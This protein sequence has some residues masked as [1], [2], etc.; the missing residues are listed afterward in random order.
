MSTGIRK[1]TLGEGKLKKITESGNSNAKVLFGLGTSNV[2]R[3]TFQT[4][5]EVLQENNVEPRAFIGVISI[6]SES[7]KSKKEV[8]I[9]I[10]VEGRNSTLGIFKYFFRPVQTLIISIKMPYLVY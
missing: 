6:L 3:E 4:E 7:F 1:R 9:Q 10:L 5:L 8:Y 2:R